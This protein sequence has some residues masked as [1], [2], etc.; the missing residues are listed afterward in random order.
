MNLNTPTVYS[1]EAPRTT[2]SLF[3]TYKQAAAQVMGA[4]MIR[5]R[6]AVNPTSLAQTDEQHLA[7]LGSVGGS[8][9]WNSWQTALM[10]LTN[11]FAP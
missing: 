4:V 3:A 10:A 5:S 8:M 11:G 1:P 6:S 7:D 9:P 2:A